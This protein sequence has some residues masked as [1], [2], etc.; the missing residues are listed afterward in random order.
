MR[1]NPLSGIAAF[2]LLAALVAPAVGAEVVPSDAG[3][4]LKEVERELQES[5]DREQALK[6]KAGGLE[7]EVTRLRRQMVAAAESIQDAETRMSRLEAELPDLAGEERD[8]VARLESNRDRV[9]HVLMALQRLARDPPE[10][11]IAQ[12]LRPDEM[13]RSAILLRA[14]V[15]QVQEQAVQLRSELALLAQTRRGAADHKRRLAEERTELNQQRAGLAMLMETK[16]ALQRETRSHG[17][18][19]ARRAEALARQAQDLHDLIMALEREHRAR[20]ETTRQDLG[21]PP[22]QPAA[23]RPG[24]EQP[25]THVRGQLPF[26]V[27]GRLV[28][29]YG[30]ATDSGL[31]RKGIVIETRPEAQVVAPYD[32]VVV[33]AGQFRGYGQLLII[34]HGEGYHS[35]LAG[36]ARTD[37]IIGSFVLAG[38]PVGLMGSG[39]GDAPTLYVELRRNGQPINPLPWLAARKGKGSG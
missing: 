16:E 34:E 3:G 30:Q 35:L 25:I 9:V 24:G 22:T 4:R 2:L 14:A 38:E 32:G 21:A 18:E 27:A 39:D 7:A 20:E 15:P 11:L 37:G 12:P 1:A 28:G 31:A 23:R 33:F 5:R 8:K 29:L 13:V 26:P 36:L 17:Q 6:R 19:E 10:A